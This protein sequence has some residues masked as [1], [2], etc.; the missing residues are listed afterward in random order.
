MRTEAE[1][2]RRDH[3]SLGG[4]VGLSY[5]SFTICRKVHHHTN[6]VV[7]SSVGGLVQEDGGEGR[8]R[9]DG[10]ADL[11]GAVDGRAGDEAEGPLEG[12]HTQAEDEVDDLQDG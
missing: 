6:Q 9:E 1:Y 2:S 10:E 8:E 7:E 5:L 3:G 4:V 12:E 11:E